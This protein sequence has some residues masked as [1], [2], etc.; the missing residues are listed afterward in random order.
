MAYKSIY[1]LMIRLKE[2]RTKYSHIIE[3]KRQADYVTSVMK[4][5]KA[6]DE[7]ISEMVSGKLIF[8]CFYF[9]HFSRLNSISLILFWENPGALVKTIKY[10]KF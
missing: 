8:I 2:E 5:Q 3:K 4:E 7:H 9:I 1:N 6:S 10:S